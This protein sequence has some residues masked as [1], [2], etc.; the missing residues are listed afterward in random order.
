MISGMKRLEVKI[1]SG[2]ATGSRVR[3]S[4]KGEAGYGGGSAGDLF[5]VITVR[6]HSQ[7]ER[8]GENLYTE[9][10]VPLTVA[11]LGGEVQVPTVK[12]TRLAL[13]I[14]EATQNGREFRL[15][16]QGMPKLGGGAF[17]D[18]IAKVNV[19]LPEKLT[20][21]ERTLYKQLAVLRSNQ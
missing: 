15:K 16:G 17:G 13:K 20:D 3:I 18:L 19:V 12:G 2:V 6:P 8:K 14:P 9:V 4:G 1:P 5:L 7:F 21:D 10:P 11:V